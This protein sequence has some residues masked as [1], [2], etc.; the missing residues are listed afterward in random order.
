MECETFYRNGKGQFCQVLGRAVMND[1][2]SE[3][4]I[5]QELFGK[6]LKKGEYPDVFFQNWK[7]AAMEN[8]AAA[9]A[10][11]TGTVSRPEISSDTG[12]PTQPSDMDQGTDLLMAFL[13]ARTSADKLE[14]LYQM[15]D[16]V[17]DYFIDS[18]ALSLDMEIPQGILEDRYQKLVRSLRTKM[19]YGS[20]RLR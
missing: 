20:D 3:I 18:M 4:I 10:G 14:I 19:R 8:S 13:E 1:S 11:R 2:G 5:Y 9:D 7:T 16:Y 17:T 6:F 12:S 15:K